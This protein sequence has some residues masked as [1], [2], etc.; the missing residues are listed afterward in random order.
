MCLSIAKMIIK[1]KM[2]ANIYAN[3]TLYGAIF[4]LVFELD[5]HHEYPE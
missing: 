4:S 1:Q 2:H 5:K 3:N